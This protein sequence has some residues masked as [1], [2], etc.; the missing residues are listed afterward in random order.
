MTN[1]GTFE[2]LES[3]TRNYENESEIQPTN[4]YY[5]ISEDFERLFH[6]TEEGRRPK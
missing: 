3:A 4:A 1:L 2:F 5:E 6:H